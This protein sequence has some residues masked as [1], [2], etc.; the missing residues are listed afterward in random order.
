MPRIAAK[1]KARSVFSQRIVLSLVRSFLLVCASLFHRSAAGADIPRGVIHDPDLMGLIAG[2][3]IEILQIVACRSVYFPLCRRT[4]LRAAVAGDKRL[5]VACLVLMHP[6]MAES[7]RSFPFPANFTGLYTLLGAGRCGF[8]PGMYPCCRNGSGL[9]GSAACAGPRLLAVFSTGRD[10]CLLPGTP[11]VN[12]RRF[13]GC[14]LSWGRF[15]GFRL[16]RRR[17]RWFRFCWLWLSG[18]R[19]CR[20][21]FC[22]L[23]GS[24]LF[25]LR[26]R[27]L[28]SLFR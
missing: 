18:S 15:G 4:E 22:R 24:R 17:S 23:R 5:P 8:L 28:R 12:M 6:V 11:A 13:G 14:R 3:G 25:R 2:V 20:F 26:R 10:G 7:R 1:R 21:G 19:G 27:R 9:R 16:C